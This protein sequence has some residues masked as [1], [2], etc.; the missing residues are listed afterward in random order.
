MAYQLNFG[1]YFLFDELSQHLHGMTESYPDLAS[2]QSIGKSWQGRD[3][4][5]MTLT[6]SDTGTH[7]EK[8]AFYIDAISMP[9]KWRHHILPCIPSGIF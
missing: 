3:V 8:P 4:W 2:L 7:D 9:K 1:E 6:N 5:C